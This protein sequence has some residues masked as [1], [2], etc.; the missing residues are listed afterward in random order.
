MSYIVTARKWRPQLFSDVIGQTHV[1]DT[2]KSAI[3]SNQVGHA[4]L[5]SGPRGVGKTTVAR[6]F[7]KALNCEHG[8]SEEPCN[9]C[10]VCVGIQSGASLDIQELDGASNNSVDDVRSLIENIGY[11]STECRY[12]MY[13][14][15]EVHM[16]SGSAFNALLKT[17]E[18]PPPNVIFVFATT[19]PHKIP[20]T[21]L[22]R[23]Q[24]YDFH[25][26]SINDIAKKLKTITDADNINIDESSI[27]LIARRAS[28][29]MRD[30][31]SIIE[32]L[33]ASRGEM[34]TVAD[35]NEVL[36]IADREVFY[37]IIEQCHN[38]NAQGAVETFGTF[39]DEGGDLKEFIEGLL[40]HLRD[41][42]YA[43]FE[44][45][46]DNVL[47]SDDYKERLLEQSGWYKQNDV[48]RMVG[49]ITEVESSLK[50]AV[51]PVLRIEVA[52]ARMATMETTVQLKDLF[53][54]FN[55]AAQVAQAAPEAPAAQVA[56]AA[57]SE[58]TP[59]PHPTATAPIVKNEPPYAHVE[60]ETP[61]EPEEDPAR[62]SV[63]P[64]IDSI[65]KAW[66]ELA[67][68][69]GDVKP[70]IG[71][72][73]A[74]GEP[75]TFENGKL[76]LAFGDGNEF[77]IKTIESSSDTIEEIMGAFLGTKIKIVCTVKKND[78]KKKTKKNEL[79][80]LVT[81]E[82]IIDT[83]MKTFDS[84]NIESWRE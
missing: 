62:L 22:S 53:D 28:G 8:P 11:H 67:S 54:R 16:L 2:L 42:L 19:E 64:D 39:F 84:K 80:D 14:V 38:N 6:I 26:L 49:F 5:F 32:Q 68:G 56:P 47:L 9:T 69:V 35:V 45:G 73:L 17:L 46:L 37:N 15:D 82:P 77:H 36:G 20:A 7:A 29:A 72:S 60:N 4:Y 66:E 18:E 21:V 50:Y 12:K 10:T 3:R 75:D 74:L 78:D 76:T 61:P 63:Q 23:C 34:I 52:L 58:Y 48:I 13:I 30:A 79:D 27:L 41:L 51:M 71:P 31:E 81:R 57:Q 70:S 83:I 65:K 24:R 33:K 44:G 1:T 55:S 43:H 59:Q 40:G 25:R